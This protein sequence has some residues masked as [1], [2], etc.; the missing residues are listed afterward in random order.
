MTI[1][2]CIACVLLVCGIGLVAW[3]LLNPRWQGAAAYDA[4]GPLILGCLA[5]QGAV[6]IAAGTA[7]VWLIQS[8]LYG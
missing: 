1:A 4:Y 2:I 3:A 6:V 7:V 5:I 8:H